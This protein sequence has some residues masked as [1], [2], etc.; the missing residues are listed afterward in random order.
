MTSNG[1]SLPDWHAKARRLKEC[2]FG[3][4]EIARGLNKSD[5]AVRCALDPEVARRAKE[6]RNLSYRKTMDR[7]I[8]DRDP[9]HPPPSWVPAHE[10][11]LWRAVVGK[12]GVHSAAAFL[13]RHLSPR[14]RIRGTPRPDEEPVA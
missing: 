10:V 5:S 3:V 4:A 2:G 12:V 11:D 14:V 13:Q 1:H 6:R 9:D 7:K 8:M